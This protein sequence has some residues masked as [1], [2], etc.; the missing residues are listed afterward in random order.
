MNERG[1]PGLSGACPEIYRER[2]FSSQ[3]YEVLPIARELGETS[4]M[5]M[6]HPTLDASD[7]D[8]MIAATREAC[9]NAA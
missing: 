3:D 6:V 7:V 4:I 1:V 5:F 8:N 2:A 9:L